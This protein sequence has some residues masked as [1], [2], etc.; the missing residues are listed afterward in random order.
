MVA[1]LLVADLD[2]SLRFW[3]DLCG[4]EVAFAIVKRDHRVRCVFR[5]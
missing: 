2:H 1:E 4:F 5:Q 3:R